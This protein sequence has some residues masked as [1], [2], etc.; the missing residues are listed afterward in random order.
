MSFFV[1]DINLSL[2]CLANIIDYYQSQFIIR[3]NDYKSNNT[4]IVL[5]IFIKYVKR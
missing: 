1:A 2:C 5:L 3:Y 4:N